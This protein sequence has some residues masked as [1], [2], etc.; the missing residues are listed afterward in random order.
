[1]LGA[2]TNSYGL[3]SDDRTAHDHAEA[4]ARSPRVA[5]HGFAAV[6][7]VGHGVVRTFLNSVEDAEV[8]DAIVKHLAA[9]AAEYA[10]S[11]EP[12]A[13]EPVAEEPT[14]K[15]QKGKGKGKREPKRKAKVPIHL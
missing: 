2:A 5:A 6:R 11:A 7:R 10:E 13:A 8:R 4:A 9:V 3:F 15:A 14:P 1:M 12:E